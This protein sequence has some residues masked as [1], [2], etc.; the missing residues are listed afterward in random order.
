[1]RGRRGLSRELADTVRNGCC[2]ESAGK[3]GKVSSLNSTSVCPRRHGLSPLLDLKDCWTTLLLG[4]VPP[5]REMLRPRTHIHAEGRDTT[6]TACV[7][8]G[9]LAGCV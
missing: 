5:E 8:K 2:T 4:S 7:S 3:G 9:T 6:D 1:M